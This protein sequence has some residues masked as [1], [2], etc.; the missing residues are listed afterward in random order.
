MNRKICYT[1]ALPVTLMLCGCATNTRYIVE[2]FGQAHNEVMAKQIVS[3]T[4][5]P[6][7]PIMHPKRANDAVKRYLDDEIKQPKEAGEI[8]SEVE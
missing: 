2:D 5:V 3:T 4:P 8:T 6:G 7:A 1:L